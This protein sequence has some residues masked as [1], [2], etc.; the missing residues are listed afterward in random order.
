[1]NCQ[2]EKVAKKSRHRCDCI[3]PSQNIEIS[4]VKATKVFT[5]LR[6]LEKSIDNILP[7]E[8]SSDLTASG[9]ESFCSSLDPAPPSHD[10]F[11]MTSPSYSLQNKHDLSGVNNQ[12][13]LGLKFDTGSP[14]KRI[15]FPSIVREDEL[16]CERLVKVKLLEISV[17]K[18]SLWQRAGPSIKLFYNLD[19][20]IEVDISNG[21]RRS[22]VEV[23]LAR[24]MR[25]RT[26]DKVDQNNS[27]APKKKVPAYS[28]YCDDYISDHKSLSR[29]SFRNDT[30]VLKWL[31]GSLVFE[32]VGDN[33]RK[34]KQNDGNTFSRPLNR[35]I[36]LIKD[37]TP[38]DNS[39]I[40][41]GIALLPLKDVILSNNLDL[42]V[43]LPILADMGGKVEQKGDKRSN[44]KVGSIS[45]C[46]S[47]LSE[48][49]AMRKADRHISNETILKYCVPELAPRKTKN[50]L[51]QTRFDAIARNSNKSCHDGNYHKNS[52]RT[53]QLAKRNIACNETIKGV[54]CALIDKRSM[55][56]FQLEIKLSSLHIND[57][58]LAIQ[59]CHFKIVLDGGIGDIFHLD[60]RD[61]LLLRECNKVGFSWKPMIYFDNSLGK[62][63]SNL[64]D[65]KNLSIIF[66]LWK[67]KTFDE[68]CSLL[69][70]VK[71]PLS[72]LTDKMRV[73]DSGT[74]T[75]PCIVP[76]Q[77]YDIK[78]GNKKI[79][80]IWINLAIG[81]P[82]QI[83]CL[84]RFRSSCSILQKWWRRIS[85]SQT[86]V[87]KMRASN[88]QKLILNRDFSFSQK[89]ESKNN[90]RLLLK[91]TLELRPMNTCLRTRSD[92]M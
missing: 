13:E 2:E 78:N 23:K 27:S 41:K 26:C 57:E 63:L 86:K 8:V 35:S 12:K 89:N 74:R 9:Y 64:I 81:K 85:K 6:K 71:V 24:N 42:S 21:R 80:Q 18:I 22:H 53:Q 91:H 5:D 69:G 83:S 70:D 50:V 1:M 17:S 30:D 62:P 46:V 32:I 67:K 66:E 55:T 14:T 52:N 51:L 15:I 37:E 40:L 28:N 77:S 29:L 54:N 11:S 61:K 45:V 4:T 39:S 44:V 73:P 79:A 90:N 43:S 65:T 16:R 58:E 87:S 56:C 38:P 34:M 20:F 10:S 84:D 76:K 92:Y 48:T 7:A 3:R 88:D 60:E 82:N 33:E 68:K 49:D 59:P 25:S 72:L 31:E 75:V 19:Q 36:K 47:L